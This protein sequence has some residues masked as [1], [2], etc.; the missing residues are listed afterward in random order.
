MKFYKT[1]EGSWNIGRVL[2]PQGTCLLETN[3]VTGELR[4]ELIGTGRQIAKLFPTQFKKEDGS[5]YASLSEFTEATSGFFL[6]SD[7]WVG[8]QEEFDLI[9]TKI[10]TRTYNIVQY[11]N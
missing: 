6:E 10:D 9:A 1:P 7:M 2:I 11:G 3:V 5:N 8:T 4:V